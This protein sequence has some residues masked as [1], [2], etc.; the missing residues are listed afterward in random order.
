MSK[1][2]KPRSAGTYWRV[3][4]HD[5]NGRGEMYGKAHHV[6]S[7][8]EGRLP[9][10]VGSEEYR[11]KADALRAEH[12]TETVFPGSEFDELVVGHWC[13]IEGMAHNTWWMNIGGVVLWVKADSRGRPQSVSVYG[14]GIE[15]DLVPGC[16]YDLDW[17]D[18]DGPNEPDR[19]ANPTSP[20]EGTTTL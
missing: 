9:A 12:S 17:R 10:S 6:S 4:V 16:T 8:P 13:H 1:P 5:Y 2:R 18:E 11:A 14:P 3:L 7:D 20:Q 19:P 15:G